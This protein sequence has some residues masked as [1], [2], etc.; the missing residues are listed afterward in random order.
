MSK[1]K[2]IGKLANSLPDTAVVPISSGG[3]GAST[4]VAALLALGVDT[5]TSITSAAS[6]IPT[7]DISKLYS[8]TALAATTVIEIPSGTPYDGQKLT[9][10][11]EDNG[12]AQTLSWTT[13]LGGYRIIG[14]TLPITT[15]ATKLLY[16]GCIY[17]LTD[18]YWD[19]VSVAQQA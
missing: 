17:N 8:V 15:V 13:T 16:I 10:R 7:S 11:I 19:V 18:S 3:T 4:A 5:S 12:T 14:T 1:A 6:I 2:N 9:I